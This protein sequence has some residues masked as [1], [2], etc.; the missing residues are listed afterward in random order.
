[1]KTTANV[2]NN[3][4]GEKL[5]TQNLENEIWKPVKGF[6]GLYEV[7]NLG[8]VKTVERT[9]LRKSAL[10][11]FSEYLVK[12]A[13]KKPYQNKSGY[14]TIAII[15]ENKTIT[16]Y[17]HRI[18]AEAFVERISE[19]DI[20]VNHINGIKNDNRIENLEWVTSSTNN[21][22]ALD[23]GLRSTRKSMTKEFINSVLE[24]REQGLVH[25]EIAT[26]LKTTIAIVQGITSGNTY[27]RIQL[28]TI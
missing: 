13:I 25:S 9:I 10:G 2:A 16:T 27:K 1:M 4:I 7:S 6:E 23:T 15:K 24:L 22:H 5:S 3:S 17:L 12:S 14:V 11:K 19:T 20:V 8:E 21:V 26:K 18:I 28:R